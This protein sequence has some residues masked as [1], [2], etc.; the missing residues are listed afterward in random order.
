MFVPLIKTLEITMQVSIVLL[1]T[2]WLD[3]ETAE[4]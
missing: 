1:A 3:A 2:A 4:L